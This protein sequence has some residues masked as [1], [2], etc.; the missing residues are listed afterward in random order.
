MMRRALFL[1]VCLMGLVPASAVT[2]FAQRPAPAPSV[3]E[4]QTRFD[5]EPNSVRKAKLLAK[6]GDA[7]FLESRR[8]QK[9]EDYVAAV[10]VLEK[11]RDNVREAIAEAVKQHPDAEKESNGYRIIEFH[12]R[13]GLREADEAIRIVPPEYQPPLHLVR[14]DLAGFQDKLLRLLFPRR[15]GEKRAPAKPPQGGY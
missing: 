1:A 8:A 3:A 4:L 12:V 13:A 6:L 5:R 9:S 2:G 14:D 11:Y 10:L 7:Q 15:P